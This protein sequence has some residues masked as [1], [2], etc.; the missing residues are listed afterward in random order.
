MGIT[1]LLRQLSSITT[2]IH[3]KDLENLTVAVDAYVWLH[4]G[5]YACSSELCNDLP[6]SKWDLPS[7][8]AYSQVHWLLYELHRGA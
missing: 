7:I 4:K 5:A 6:T 2:P 8:L 1:G 3:L